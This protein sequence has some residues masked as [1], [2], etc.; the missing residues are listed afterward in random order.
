MSRG[1]TIVITAA[2]RGLFYEG[3]V[4][5]SETPKPGTVMQINTSVTT[6]VGGRWTYK[7]YAAGTDGHRR[8]MHI[9]REDDLQGKLMTDAYAANDVAFL[10]CPLAGDELNM[11]VLNISG[12]GDD[13]AFGEM[14]MVDTGTGKL[15]VESSPESEPF[16][17][18][19]AITDPTADTLAHVQYTGY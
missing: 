7:A 19:E 3:I 12:T 8:T 2:P 15:V 5:N 14:L 17:L 9:L 4:G 18:L 6:M 13:H 16:Q 11:L 10:Y 1:N